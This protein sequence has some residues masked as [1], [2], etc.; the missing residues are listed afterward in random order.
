MRPTLRFLAGCDDDDELEIA[1]A[2]EGGAAPDMPGLF[3]GLLVTPLMLVIGLPMP[4]MP[5]MPFIL[6]MLFMFKS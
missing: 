3:M 4:F 5:F 1:A 2:P 6:F